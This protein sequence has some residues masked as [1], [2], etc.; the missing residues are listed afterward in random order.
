ME[1]LWYKVRRT[2]S[3]L[4][5][6]AMAMS[7]TPAGAFAEGSLAPLDPSAAAD[8]VEP[9]TETAANTVNESGETPEEPGSVSAESAEPSVGS[10]SIPAEPAG[11]P[12]GESQEGPGQAPSVDNGLSAP[13][14]SESMPVASLDESAPAPSESMPVASSD[15]SVPA[16]SESVPAASSDESESAPASSESMPAASSDESE[17]APASSESM[18]AA[19]SDESESVPASSE[20]MPAASSDESESVP[21]D[22][23]ADEESQNYT[24]HVTHE[25]TTNIGVFVDE[26][27]LTL[28]DA[29]FVNGAYDPAALA[30]QREGL[31]FKGATQVLLSDVQASGGSASVTLSY[32]VA[33][34]YKAVLKNASGM[35][36]MSTYTG[37]FD[38]VEI[39]PV[40]QAAV[41]VNFVLDGITAVAPYT[42]MVSKDGSNQFTVNEDLSTYLN[43]YL[44]G[45]EVELDT[46]AAPGADLRLDGTTLTGTVPADER[47][48][49]T[50]RMTSKELTYTVE[51]HFPGVDG[52]G[53]TVETTTQMGRF[54]EQTD[55]QPIEKP[56]FAVGEIK[57]VLLADASQ[58]Y[59][60]HIYYVRE[61][62]TLT[63]D[64]RG[65]SYV[66]PKYGQYGETVTIYDRT[67]EQLI[68]GLEEHTYTT[69]PS[70]DGRY[71]GQEDGCWRWSNGFLG[72][73][74]GWKR[75][76]GLAEH[77]HSEKCYEAVYSPEPSRQ[78]YVFTGWYTDAG[79]TTPVEPTT[80]LTE[81]MT[82]YA[83]W[84]AA[85]VNYTVAYY[86]ENANDNGYSYVGSVVMTGETGETVQAKDSSNAPVDRNHFTFQ[87]STQATVAADGS[88]VITAYYSRNAYTLTFKDGRKTVATKR[89]KYEAYIGDWWVENVGADSEYAGSQWSWDGTQRTVYQET[90]PGENKTCTL[91]EDSGTK[92]TLYYYV[93]DS[94]GDIRDPRGGDRKFRL[95]TTTSFRMSGG[96]LTYD[97]EYFLIDGYDRYYTDVEQWN[98]GTGNVSLGRKTEFH[99]YY[100]RSEY[101]LTLVNGSERDEQNVPFSEELTSYLDPDKLTPP[102]EGAEFV[103]WYLDPS[104]A[105]PNTYETMPQGLILYAKWNLPKYEV[106]FVEGHDRPNEVQKV[107][108][109]GKA[110]YY[111]PDGHSGY[112][113]EGWYADDA[114]T[115]PFDFNQ[116]ITGNTTVYAKWKTN[117]TMEYT[118][119][120]VTETGEAVAEPVTKSGA[121]GSTVVE[122]AVQATGDYADYVPDATSKSLKLEAG[123]PA[124][125]VFTYSTLS[126]IQ[127]KVQYVYNDEPLATSEEFTAEA[128]TFVVTAD[129]ETVKTLL[130]KGYALKDGLTQKQVTVYPGQENVVTFEL[131]LKEFT[132]TYELNGGTVTPEDANPDTYTVNTPDFTLENPERNGY[133]FV[134]W[135]TGSGTS[136]HEGAETEVTISKGSTGDLTFV[137][138]WEKDEDTYSVFYKVQSVDGY[139]DYNGPE[140]DSEA[141]F[142]AGTEISAEVMQKLGTAAQSGITVQ[143][144]HI[145]GNDGSYTFTYQ[146]GEVGDGR[147]ILYFDRVLQENDL[148]NEYV[149]VSNAK[150][151]GKDAVRQ[152]KITVKYALLDADGNVGEAR[153]VG[154]GSLYFKWQDK[155]MVDLKIAAADGW[156]LVAAQAAQSDPKDASVTLDNVTGNTEI[157]IYL[158]Q[159]YTVNYHGADGQTTGTQTFIPGAS[160]TVGNVSLL[161]Q[162]AVTGWPNAAELPA[163]SVGHTVSGWYLS[164]EGGEIAVAAGDSLTVGL[165]AD[166]DRMIDLYAQET[167][168]TYTLTVNAIHATATG[169]GTTYSY[170]ESEKTTV[171]FQPDLGYKIISV[172][173]DGQE[174]GEDV[175]AAGCVDVDHTQ[176][177]T[178]VVTAEIDESQTKDLKAT[179]DYKLGDEVQV[180]DHKDLTATVQI[181]EPDTLSTAGVET[182]VYTG[183]KLANITI[184]GEEVESLPETVNNGDAVVYNYI[185]DSFAYQ[186]NHIYVGRDGSVLGTVA[187]EPGSGLFGDPIQY[188][189][190][191]VYNDQTFIFDR[192]DG[193]ETIG[194]DAEANVLNVYYDIDAN[195]DTTPD[196]YQVTVDYVAA[197]GEV[198]GESTV[199]LTLTG[200]D[201]EPATAEDGGKAAAPEKTV[202]PNE[203]HTWYD[204]NWYT[205]GDYTEK[206]DFTVTADTTFY[207]YCD[208]DVLVDPDQDPDPETPGDQ[209]PDKFQATIRYVSADEAK[210]TTAPA[211]EVT[212]I[213]EEGAYAEEG[214]VVIG[215]STATGSE[216][217]T[218]DCWTKPDGSKSYDSAVLAAEELAVKGGETYV[219][220][221][222]F[223][224]DEK[225]EPDPTDPDKEGG[226]E[227]PDQYQTFFKFV[228]AGNGSVTGETYEKHNGVKGEEKPTV[229]PAAN[230]TVTADEGYAF[231]HWTDDS[232]NVYWTLEDVRAVATN[233]DTT[234]TAHFDTDT[235]GTDP[236]NPD[237]G[238]NVPDKYQAAVTYVAVNGTVTLAGETGTELHTY[239]TLADE[240]GNWSE[241]GTGVLSDEQIPVSQ[242]AAGYDPATKA[243]TPASP[244]DSRTI[245]G[246]TTFTVSWSALPVIDETAGYQVH[247]FYD[248]TEDTASAVNAEGRIG[249]TI[250]Y[251]VNKTTFNGAN[252]LL[253]SVDG[254]GRLISEDAAAN[255]VN[256]YFTKDDLADPDK[257]PDPETPGDGIPDK[258]QAAVTFEAINGVV[259]PKGGTEMDNKKSLTT[260]VTLV[261]PDGQ[262]AEN[263]TGYLTDAQI[264]NALANTGYNGSAPYWTPETPTTSY[265]IT[266]DMTFVVDF[267]NLPVTPETP[268]AP[269]T[270]AGPTTPAAPDAPTAPDEDG[271][272]GPVEPEE[273]T[274][275][276]EEEEIADDETPMAAPDAGE[277]IED[278]STPLA[279]NPGA[280]WALLNLILM[281]LTALGSVV[282]LVSYVGKKKK[283]Q[284]NENGQKE[285]QYT[286]KKKGFWRVFSLVPGIGSIIAFLLTENMANPM[287]FTDRWTLLMV[288]IALVKVIVAVLAIKKK[289]EPD[290]DRKATA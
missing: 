139:G 90:M 216:G 109:N 91:V 171:T 275:A 122:K 16:S 154:D 54:N 14:P 12:S 84:R 118:V 281:I 290:E 190:K 194:A 142:D 104:F 160:A 80:Q 50:V 289:D 206:A 32:E 106:T 113:F 138:N 89:A 110:E 145:D 60:V 59:T 23:M 210:G 38:D 49:V 68:C 26:A 169:N 82:V 230:V 66:A 239:V 144:L 269:A 86:T 164:A 222:S 75:N 56:G 94:S 255:I 211:E 227:I 43:Q 209:I 197:N 258:Y 98:H 247:Y 245:T 128:Q 36:T 260:V 199:V 226:D 132:I 184:N 8:V 136:G 231:D 233:A 4:L 52:A 114:Y 267:P 125:I 249:E 126:D 204:Q 207:A 39:V 265:A 10:E 215:G 24:L 248:G 135:T 213:G 235:K 174:Q 153:P 149:T 244:L 176:A 266:G 178:V 61:T 103:G 69:K 156:T 151:P 1:K 130:R 277:A 150:E 116:P 96:S 241:T 172:T 72:F 147:I 85:Q 78:G 107:E 29:D 279:G 105:E 95:Y 203:G 196:K 27:T 284:E 225:G 268:D 65:G 21:T 31:T 168:N 28:T 17:S 243:W 198:E 187:D 237:E 185:R 229:S 285:L 288:L 250:P 186:V 276:A 74:K 158:A 101:P 234:F 115:T 212:T 183:W 253:E 179:V 20:S 41:T 146:K 278:E 48:S 67:G 34:G 271:E 224:V 217:Y 127:Y 133:K 119:K 117:T 83:G 35:I 273:E 42:F 124:E 81:N 18:P 22:G 97:E 19:S 53:E 219:Y 93:E 161:P 223:A 157:I 262:P 152:G 220:T 13:A 252:Y 7:T 188:E 129:A 131:V 111:T 30:Y 246:D 282:L 272:T 11:E 240:N 58:E 99:F 221:A 47:Y 251:D 76:C 170:S 92:R 15:E 180:N 177:H 140:A 73:G 137:A 256:V 45:C 2:V 175:I 182:K 5:V 195:N 280:A 173:L 100:T 264:P 274:P 40:G 166:Q 202:Q 57:N 228:S 120:Y 218:F 64:S 112:T 205:S 46:A 236:E 238:D 181:L 3:I 201:G 70:K 242:E 141:T 287:V 55:A 159:P 51:H 44:N 155:N 134:G 270:P 121:V 162:G 77:R 87:R 189:Q 108:Y 191:L 143:D 254:E 163:A 214:T 62:Y 167:A 259:Q 192:V 63:Y 283:E 6:V 79:C 165:D 286:V 261:G 102:V 208:T 123:G 193:A 88:T 263:G 9:G 33:P 71:D 25:L 148:S 257:D 232:G 37:T 200:D